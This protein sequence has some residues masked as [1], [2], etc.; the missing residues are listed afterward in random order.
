MSKF[1]PNTNIWIK[2]GLMLQTRTQ[3][4]G[5]LRTC[6]FSINN[7]LKL[8]PSPIIITVI[9]I[10]VSILKLVEKQITFVVYLH[11]YIY[12][13]N[14][15][16]LLLWEIMSIVINKRVEKSNENKGCIRSQR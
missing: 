12:I 5:G 14:N 8:S 10:T 3:E 4:D 1:S 11:I 16:L 6:S 2:K 9:D 15:I 13:K 7:Q